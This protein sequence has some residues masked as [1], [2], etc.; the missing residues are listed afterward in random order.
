MNLERGIS[1]FMSKRRDMKSSGPSRKKKDEFKSGIADKE[2]GGTTL[3]GMPI[4]EDDFRELRRRDLYYAD[5]ASA[6]EI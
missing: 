2:S 1:P 3:E 5:S 4:G 6:T